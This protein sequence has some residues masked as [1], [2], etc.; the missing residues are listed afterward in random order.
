M[1]TFL[2]KELNPL[3]DA[4]Y[5][6]DYLRNSVRIDSIDAIRTDRILLK[7]AFSIY[8]IQV[9]HY[10]VLLLTWSI[11]EK[12]VMF[13]ILTL[14]GLD[15]LCNLF[16]AIIEMMGAFL[17]HKLYRHHNPM[18]ERIL[19]AIFSQKRTNYFLATTYKSK[20][21]L[22]YLRDLLNQVLA[23]TRSFNLG[24]GNVLNHTTFLFQNLYN[25]I[26]LDVFF[27]YSQ[28]LLWKLITDNWNYFYQPSNLLLSAWKIL[29]A[30][31][32]LLTFDIALGLDAHCY[33]NMM[34]VF[35]AYTIVF[36][37]KLNQANYV[38]DLALKRWRL[39]YVA[40]FMHHHTNTFRDV[41]EFNSR[42]NKQLLVYAL[43][44]LP[45]NVFL[46]SNTIRNSNMGQTN[47]ILSILS[48]LVVLQQLIVILI[49]HLICALYTKKIHQHKRNLIKVDV[50]IRPK[51]IRM[52]LKIAA[53]IE[54]FHT[55]RQYGMTYFSCNLITMK[56]FIK[57]GNL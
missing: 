53:Y 41:L 28:Y 42:Y 29:F 34:M 12:I 48:L 7:V 47:S 8:G 3:K 20:P 26:F 49:L 37:V 19:G 10:F 38:L 22:D 2:A 50:R 44:T 13:D 21:V 15:K 16:G 14:Y 1:L 23:Q 17:L 18:H 33:I 55:K 4:S 51:S 56:T 45:M 27:I 32:N 9:I 40:Y 46:I 30:E 54:K 6:T 36:F 39:G 52:Q 57:V 31:F 25:P 35:V 24:V 11:P 43:A 5:L